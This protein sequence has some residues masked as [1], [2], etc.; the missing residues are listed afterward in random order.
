ME[1]FLHDNGFDDYQ[2]L[3]ESTAELHA[4]LASAIAAGKSINANRFRTKIDE[5]EKMQLDALRL[6]PVTPAV[7]SILNEIQY[8]DVDGLVQDIEDKKT[9]IKRK[10]DQNKP[11]DAER[12]SKELDILKDAMERICLSSSGA[13]V[14][15]APPAERKRDAAP[16]TQQP[17]LPVSAPATSLPASAKPSKPSAQVWTAL[18]S[19]FLFLHLRWNCLPPLLAARMSPPNQLRE[20]R[21]RPIPH[22][23]PL[24]AFGPRHC[25]WQS[26]QRGSVLRKALRT[27]PRPLR[28]DS[29]LGKRS[30]AWKSPW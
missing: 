15:P 22:R 19:S 23:H 11:R 6:A 29:R 12:V 20:I 26:P 24:R 16:P 14:P 1:S 7:T 3:Q 9:E 21:L 13:E 10:V 30:Q 27:P 4:N 2:S 28:P 8:D 17:P 25:R 5:Q 18:P